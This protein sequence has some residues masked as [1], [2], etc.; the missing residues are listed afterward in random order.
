MNTQNRLLKLLRSCAT[1]EQF[2]REAIHRSS[3]VLRP[4]VAAGVNVNRP[5]LELF[6]RQH[7]KGDK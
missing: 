2:E 7:T 1:Y 4:Y 5:W 3:W 6:Y